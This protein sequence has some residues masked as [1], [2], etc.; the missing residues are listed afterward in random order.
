MST[1]PPS[2]TKT[3]LER[4]LAEAVLEEGERPNDM[5]DNPSGSPEQEEEEV[6]S[7]SDSECEEVMMEAAG[8]PNTGGNL[9]A[10]LWSLDLSAS[11]VMETSVYETEVGEELSPL[12]LLPG[13]LFTGS[14]HRLSSP[15]I[16]CMVLSN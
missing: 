8:G 9:E 4:E 6:G 3:R 2:A 1:A 15:T 12:I 14:F 5:G 7:D 13:F 10:S 11:N 16:T